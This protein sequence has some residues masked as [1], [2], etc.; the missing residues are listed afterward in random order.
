MSEKSF[1]LIELLMNAV[2]Q[3]GVLYSTRRTQMFRNGAFV[4]ISTEEYG[5]VR[6]SA[7]QN[8]AGFAQQQNTPLFLKRERG[9]G[10]RGKL[11][12]S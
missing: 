9:V 11:L 10:E 6:S 3:T 12:F 2:C 1:T 4:R 5:R 7:P 8:T